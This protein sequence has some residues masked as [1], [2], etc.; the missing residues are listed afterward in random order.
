M[1]RKLICAACMT[2]VLG[3]AS[4]VYADLVIGDWEQ[5]MD[6]WQIHGDAPEGTDIR[7]S[8][9]NGVTLGD[10]SLDVYVPVGDYKLILVYNIVGQ[11]ILDDFRKY[12]KISLDVNDS[13]LLDISDPLALLAYL[14]ANG[15]EPPLPGAEPGIDWT[16]D[17]LTCDRPC[18]GYQTDFWPTASSTSPK[19]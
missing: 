13:G 9:S 8:D 6:G 16:P 17:K 14:F 18:A 7:Y 2:V 3:L 12:Q 11:G 1:F 10:Y 19:R 15:A 4:A 5:D